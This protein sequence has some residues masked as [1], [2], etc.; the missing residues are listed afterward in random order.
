MV[1]SA[2]YEQENVVCLFRV[3]KFTCRHLFSLIL[4]V[5]KY[6]RIKKNG[7]R[8]VNLS[9]RKLLKYFKIYIKIVLKKFPVYEYYVTRS[10]AWFEN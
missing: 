9:M 6:D 4:S 10:L 5:L 3:D 8:H 7:R 2:I 1:N